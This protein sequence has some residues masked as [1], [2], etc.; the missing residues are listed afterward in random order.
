MR[1]YKGGGGTPARQEV[2]STKLPAYA[3]PYF[4]RLLGRA[5]SES[6]Q[7]YTPFG[8]ERL[9][10][11]GP[12]EATSQAMTR[13]FA[14]AGTPEEFTQA[15]GNIQDIINTGT[16]I[17]PYERLSFEDGIN[18]FMNPYQQGV[19]DM[20]QREAIRTS[21]ILGNQIASKAAQ[22]GGLGG[23][24]EAI[25]QSERERNL[26]QRLDDIQTKGQDRAF[27]LAMQ[28]LARERQVGLQE[29]QL[30]QA[31]DRLG[32]AGSRSLADIGSLTQQDAL[33]RIGALGRI[34]EQERAMRQAGLDIGYDDFTRQRDF[35]RNQL[36]FFSNVLQ[37]IP[38]KPDQTVSTFQRQPGLLQQATGAGLTGL[39]IYRA[40][41]PGGGGQA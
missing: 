33:A 27:N 8:G 23:Y 10:G 28:Q 22:S 30:R 37:G 39:G 4:T 9:A 34:G 21:N 3:E 36:G 24:R 2:F 41:Q 14:T 29:E 18:Q 13:G 12:D 32:L 19:I 25:M 35:A 7:Q 26:G 20:A 15:S 1:R 31:A 5:E 11:F 17:N 6:L 16:N 38:I 40:L